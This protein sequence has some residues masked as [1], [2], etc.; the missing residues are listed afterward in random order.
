M[1]GYAHRHATHPS[2]SSG[3][4]DGPCRLRFYSRPRFRYR[5]WTGWTVQVDARNF[6]NNFTFYKP[7]RLC[8]AEVPILCS[9]VAMLRDR[10]APKCGRYGQPR[11]RGYA[12][13]QIRLDKMFKINKTNFIYLNCLRFLPTVLVDEI[14]LCILQS[15]VLS[16]PDIAG[17]SYVLY[18]AQIF[19]H[20]YMTKLKRLDHF[21]TTF[22]KAKKI[23]KVFTYRFVWRV[24]WKKSCQFMMK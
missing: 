17:C 6:C 5:R 15:H 13:F 3:E 11:G 18:T 4:S 24:S 22:K 10:Q 21:V 16:T 23:V 9:M 12:D 20:S 1:D 7:G 8:R 19:L 14:L 2:G